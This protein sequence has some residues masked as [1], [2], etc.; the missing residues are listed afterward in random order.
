MSLSIET[1]NK[2]IP[3]FFNEDG[4]PKSNTH[5]RIYTF[6]GWSISQYA[7]VYSI[8]SFRALSWE[9]TLIAWKAVGFSGH[10]IGVVYCAFGMLFLPRIPRAYKKAFPYLPSYQLTKKE[11]ET[12]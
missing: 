6:I 7:L 9:K 2:L 5:K 10:V 8:M 4:T 11:T 3:F 1:S 12:K